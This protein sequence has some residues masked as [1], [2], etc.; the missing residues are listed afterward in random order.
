MGSDVV[1]IIGI[2]PSEHPFDVDRLPLG[3]VV[4]VGIPDVSGQL[5]RLDR[6][7]AGVDVAADGAF[8]AYAPEFGV[9]F[10]YVVQGLA[11]EDPFGDDRIHLGDVLVG[12]ALVDPGLVPFPYGKRIGVDAV[13]VAFPVRAVL[14]FRASVAA[15]GPAPPA[16]AFVCLEKRAPPV[17]EGRPFRLGAGLSAVG[18]CVP[19]VFDDGVVEDLAVYRGPGFAKELCGLRDGPFLGDGGLEVDP[20]VVPDSLFIFHIRF[21]FLRRA[22]G[23]DMIAKNGGSRKKEA[24]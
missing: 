18:A 17:L 7:V 2:G 9:G 14:G 12:D 22:A 5:V 3:M 15:I 16:F 20:V 23:E 6:K 4:F 24:E 19:A 1:P 11:V 21:S 13:V 8:A 10:P